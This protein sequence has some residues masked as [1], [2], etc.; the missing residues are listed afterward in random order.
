MFFKT[1]FTKPTKRQFKITVKFNLMLSC[2]Y[3]DRQVMMFWFMSLPRQT[4]NDVLVYVKFSCYE[5]VT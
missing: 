1:F 3:Q 5:G 2:H 4:G